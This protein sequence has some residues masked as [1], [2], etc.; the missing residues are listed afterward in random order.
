VQELPTTQ[1]ASII[2]GKN[3]VNA[4]PNIKSEVK[5]FGLVEDFL[6]VM[7]RTCFCV[8]TSQNQQIE[9]Y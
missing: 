8:L 1:D 7:G 6:D 2:C 3:S 5:A 4:S 9:T